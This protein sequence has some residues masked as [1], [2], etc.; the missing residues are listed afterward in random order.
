MV[1]NKINIYVLGENFTMI[2]EYSENTPEKYENLK[3]YMHKTMP[4][5]VLTLKQ[6]NKVYKRIYVVYPSL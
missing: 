3:D 1:S 2:I 5:A 4:N 6:R